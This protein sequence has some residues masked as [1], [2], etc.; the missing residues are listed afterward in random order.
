MIFKNFPTD[1]RTINEM[2]E[3]VKQFREDTFHNEWMEKALPL[4]VASR[5]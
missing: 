4:L 1:N 3:N 5:K 2:R